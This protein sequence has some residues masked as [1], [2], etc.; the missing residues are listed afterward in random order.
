[1]INTLTPFVRIALRIFGGFMIGN[2]YADVENASVYFQNAE[3]IGAISLII[4]ESWYSLA[5]KFGWE[6]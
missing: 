5:R 1:M 4:S 6:K 2:G 3:L